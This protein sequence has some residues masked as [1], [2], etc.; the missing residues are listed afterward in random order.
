M[1]YMH[2]IAFCKPG[3]SRNSVPVRVNNR[4]TEF[5]FNYTFTAEDAQIGK[6]NFKAVATIQNYRDALPGDNEYIS[7]PVKVSR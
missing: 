1:I 2:I 3:W 4:T 5:V 7:L 6:V